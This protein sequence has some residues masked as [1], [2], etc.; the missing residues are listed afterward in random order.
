MS[1]DEEGWGPWIEHDGG[2]GPNITAKMM[3]HWVGTGIGPKR[4]ERT[5]PHYPCWLWRW[6]RVRTG[7][8]KSELVRVC[9]NPTYAPIIR[10]RIYR[11]RALRDLIE[12]VENLPAPAREG[13]DA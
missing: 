4:D 7:W 2:L 8:F 11:P 1:D 9:D 13:V 3:V 10:Y 12:L 6:K 5:N